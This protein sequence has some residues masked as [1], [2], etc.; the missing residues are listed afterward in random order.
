MVTDVVYFLVIGGYYCSEVALAFVVFTSLFSCSLPASF[1]APFDGGCFVMLVSSSRLTCCY[2]YDGEGSIFNLSVLSS[3]SPF[4]S[5][6]L[7]SCDVVLGGVGATV[8]TYCFPLAF[9]YLPR[10]F[11]PGADTVYLNSSANVGLVCIF[12]RID[13]GCFFSGCRPNSNID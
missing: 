3:S 7:S 13:S 12:S 8:I 9:F 2:Y 6:A 5:T 10:F 1:S 11:S 4:S